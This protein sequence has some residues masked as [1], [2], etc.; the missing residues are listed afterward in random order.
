MSIQEYLKLATQWSVVRRSVFFA[1]VVGSILVAINHGRC[2]LAGKFNLNCMVSCIL[3]VIVP[4]CVSTIS[5][6]LARQDD[7]GEG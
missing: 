3:T 4:Y 2:V 5:S 6:V 1:I 7:L